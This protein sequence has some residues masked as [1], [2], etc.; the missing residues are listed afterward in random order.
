MKVSLSW[1]RD[2]DLKKAWEIW[3]AREPEADAEA[4][5]GKVS[6]DYR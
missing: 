6:T 3:S 2:L 5:Y 1:K 4:M